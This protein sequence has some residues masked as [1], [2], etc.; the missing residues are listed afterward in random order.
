MRHSCGSPPDQ[1]EEAQ[2]PL[3]YFVNAVHDRELK[4]MMVHGRR[5]MALVV[6]NTAPSNPFFF[7]H[8]LPL[9]VILDTMKPSSFLLLVSDISPSPITDP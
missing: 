4:F 9:Q 8:W 3:P 1:E 5:S 2:L 6:F 7:Q